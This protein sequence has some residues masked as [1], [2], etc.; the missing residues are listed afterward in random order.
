MNSRETPIFSS[1]R[2][3][4]NMHLKFE[5]IQYLNPHKECSGKYVHRILCFTFV[6]MWNLYWKQ[7]GKNLC[8]K[9]LQFSFRDSR[10]WKQCHGASKCSKIS[11]FRTIRLWPHKRERRLLEALR[12]A[13]RVKIFLGV[14]GTRWFLIV[15]IAGSHWLSCIIW[16]SY[17]KNPFFHNIYINIF[18]PSTLRCAVRCVALRLFDQNLALY[19]ENKKITVLHG[20]PISFSF[21]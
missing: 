20:Q 15:S 18:L 17:P 3:K 9:S 10:R 13:Q 19:L 7:Y 5:V 21:I 16:H 4:K 12:V 2:C 14:Y 8:Q 11:G 6:V 1:E